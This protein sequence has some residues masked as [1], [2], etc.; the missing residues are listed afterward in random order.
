M[1]ITNIELRLSP[2]GGHE[3]AGGTQRDWRPL[4][5]FL[6][7]FINPDN[8]VIMTGWL[9]NTNGQSKGLTRSARLSKS[10]FYGAHN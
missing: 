5:L 3:P 4:A 1:Q 2:Y 6:S 10:H 9:V 8:L 7:Q